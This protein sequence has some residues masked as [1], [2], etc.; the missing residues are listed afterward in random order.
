MP[1]DM[2][3]AVYP[4]GGGYGPPQDRAPELIIDDL[5]NDIVSAESA[6]ELYR[7]DRK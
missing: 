1:G 2:V 5:R 4:G 3:E 7:S 6:K